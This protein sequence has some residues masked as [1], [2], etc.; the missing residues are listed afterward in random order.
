MGCKCM[1]GGSWS[2]GLA[3]ACI[4]NYKSIPVRVTVRLHALCTIRHMRMLVSAIN[5]SHFLAIYN[6]DVL[7]PIRLI[8][9]LAEHV[10]TRLDPQ[11]YS[12][13]VQ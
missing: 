9:A 13:R 6:S 2:A 4:S 3:A 7:W 5:L 8:W 1:T 12:S 10:H 11:N